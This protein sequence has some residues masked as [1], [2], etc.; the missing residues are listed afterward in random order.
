[1]KK[2]Y[3]VDP[4]TNKFLCL[5]V[6]LSRINV[7]H[8][9]LHNFVSAFA[10]AT[11]FD[12]FDDIKRIS[13]DY[14]G[15]MKFIIHETDIEL[16]YEN[17]SIVFEGKE[18][19]SSFVF[20]GHAEK[21][22]YSPD[23]RQ[24]AILGYFVDRETGDAAARGAGWYGSDGRHDK[25]VTVVHVQLEDGTRLAFDMD[26]AIIVQD[27]TPAQRKARET[28][29]KEEALAKLTPAERK[30]LGLE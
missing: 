13:K 20:L 9:K 22:K 12:S 3:A 7:E 10:N 5:Q 18:P 4:Y 23:E 24:T 11:F 25:H 15:N 6:E 27:E 28:K 19:N 8:N 29:L 21:Y 14:F 26:D 17:S 16:D 30:L 1:M 2:Y